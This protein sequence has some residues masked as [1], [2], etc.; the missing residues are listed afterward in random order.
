MKPRLVHLRL[1][2]GGAGYV[3]LVPGLGRSPEE[4]IATHS[5][6][7]TRNVPWTKEPGGS[8]SKGLQGALE[9]AQ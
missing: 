2:I 5:S 3:G 4:E 1:R 6:I 9:H 7:P 8:Q